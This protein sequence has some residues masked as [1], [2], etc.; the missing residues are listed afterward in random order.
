MLD[1]EVAGADGVGAG[2]QRQDRIG[3]APRDQERGQRAEEGEE[4]GQVQAGAQDLGELLARRRQRQADA[5]QPDDL[6]PR[7]GAARLR[8]HGDGGGARRGDDRRP[9]IVVALG[10]D[11]H[12]RRVG[13]GEQRAPA[14]PAAA[15][16]ACRAP[17][18]RQAQDL[19]AARIVDADQHHV[20]FAEGAARRQIAQRRVAGVGAELGLRGQ[21]GEQRV[22]RGARDPS[23]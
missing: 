23:R 2:G 6:A 21:D 12:R 15:A 3:D 1:V 19:A 4:R 14:A 16:A 11:A 13:I 18:Q 10:G 9:Q 20:V 8:R 5:R 17:A 7:R 22:R